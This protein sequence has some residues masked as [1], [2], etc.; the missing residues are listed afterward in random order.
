[1]NIQD[2][3]SLDENAKWKEAALIKA[4][5]SKDYLQRLRQRMRDVAILQAYMLIFDTDFDNGEEN[6]IY[7][8]LGQTLENLSQDFEIYERAI[9]KKSDK[10]ILLDLVFIEY[11]QFQ[12][13]YEK[14]KAANI[15]IKTDTGLNWNYSKQSLAEYFGKQKQD[16]EV[17]QWQHIEKLFTIK[18]QKITGLKDSFNQYRNTFQKESKD[19]EAIKKIIHI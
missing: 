10:E 9:L 1:M 13:D 6:I 17:I 2:T 3:I 15:F 11:P 5:N 19:Y 16:N 14:L 4:D 18:N 8:G 7:K 12:Q